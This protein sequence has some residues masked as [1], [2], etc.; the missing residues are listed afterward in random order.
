MNASTDT[1]KPTGR[2]T[3]LATEVEL[4]EG[5]T[6]YTSATSFSKMKQLKK[7]VIV[8]LLLE[9]DVSSPGLDDLSAM[10]KPALEQM[11]WNM[12]HHQFYLGEA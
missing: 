3:K 1:P 6:K 10:N 8:A 2:R 5:R 12:V 11:L 9:L 7:S 4:Q